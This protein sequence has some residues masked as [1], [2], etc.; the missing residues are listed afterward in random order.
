[1]LATSCPP[2]KQ[3]QDYLAG[4]LDESG[5]DVL[6]QHLQSCQRCELA[7]AELDGGRW[8]RWWSC[9]RVALQRQERVREVMK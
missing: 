9:C 5:S 6:E 1:M 8:I 3:L 7:T 4:K 2:R